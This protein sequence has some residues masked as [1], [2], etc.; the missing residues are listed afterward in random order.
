MDD[1]EPL[2]ALC[3]YRAYIRLPCLSLVYSVGEHQVIH[4]SN[5][6]TSFGQPNVLLT[7]NDQNPVKTTIQFVTE[8]ALLIR[9]GILLTYRCLQG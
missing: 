2:C 3:E 9:T 7:A 8:H 5:G 1:A 4:W 6:R